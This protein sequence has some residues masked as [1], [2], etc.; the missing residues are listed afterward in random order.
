MVVKISTYVGGEDIDKF[1]EKYGENLETF[2]CLDYIASLS[3]LLNLYRHYRI[4]NLH[5]EEAFEEAWEYVWLFTDISI[6]SIDFPDFYDDVKRLALSFELSLKN[7]E[8]QS[9]FSSLLEAIEKIFFEAIEE[10][11]REAEETD[12]A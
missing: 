5:S 6:L 3:A 9:T 10:L 12:A 2:D 8:E 4:T 1:V 7:L 11:E